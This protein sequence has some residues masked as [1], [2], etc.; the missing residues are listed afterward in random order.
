[1]KR[2][3]LLSRLHEKFYPTRVPISEIPRPVV[4]LVQVAPVLAL[5]G[6]AILLAILLLLVEIKATY[7]KE[8]LKLGWRRLNQLLFGSVLFGPTN[9]GQRGRM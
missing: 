2:N 3:G 4:S 6:T 8:Y 5:L 7:I 1:M 9:A